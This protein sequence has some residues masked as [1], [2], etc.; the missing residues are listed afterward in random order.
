MGSILKI[1]GLITLLLAFMVWYTLRLI[2]QIKFTFGLTY[3]DLSK[4]GSIGS[5]SQGNSIIKVGLRLCIQNPLSYNITLKNLS[6][7]LYHE[8]VEVARSSEINDQLKNINILSNRETCFET[9]TDFVINPK[10]VSLT[11]KL[12]TK[13]PAEI[14]YVVKGKFYFIPISKKGVYI[15]NEPAAV[16]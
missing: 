7:Q 1:F 15:V 3:L 14:E 12:K 10:L 8:G 11:Y 13:A 5:F 6:Y 16:K 2:G 4:L 9:N